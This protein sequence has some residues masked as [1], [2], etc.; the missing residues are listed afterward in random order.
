MRVGT[1]LLAVLAAVPALAGNTDQCVPY[2]RSDNRLTFMKSPADIDDFVSAL[3]DDDILIPVAL[4]I[5]DLV[6]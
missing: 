2:S 1:L 6:S 4:D 3:L 5:A